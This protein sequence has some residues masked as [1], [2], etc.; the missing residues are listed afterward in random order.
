MPGVGEGVSV[1][2]AQVLRWMFDLSC[3]EF[4]TAQWFDFLCIVGLDSSR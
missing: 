2:E 3:T 1:T 4:P